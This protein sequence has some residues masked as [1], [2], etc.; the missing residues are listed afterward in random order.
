MVI[1]AMSGAARLIALAVGPAAM[2]FAHYHAR[3]RVHLVQKSVQVLLP[4]GYVMIIMEMAAM[5]G[6]LRQTVGAA[7]LV[8]M[9]CVHQHVQA[10]A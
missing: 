5:S 2:V 9:A 10:Y 6:A 1:H 3:V 8:A 7:R 4:T